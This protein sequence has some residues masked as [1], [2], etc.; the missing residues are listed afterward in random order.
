MAGGI[1]LRPIRKADAETL[2]KNINNPKIARYTLNIPHPYKLKD[3]H[4]W[5][6]HNLKIRKK[7]Q[8]EK[9]NW[10]IVKD[11]EV[12]GSV[13]INTLTYSGIY[14]HRAE[15][16]YWLAEQYWG[17]G[18]MPA[19]VKKVITFGFKELGLRRIEAHVF[20]A[21][22]QSARVLEKNGFKQEGFLKKYSFKNGKYIDEYLYAKVK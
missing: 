10:M 15:F 16:G 6:E 8:P 20:K 5:I 17:Q 14:R 13:G 9:I 1:L 3:A 19:A 2:T 4:W 22:K 21:N 12:I 18:I 7:K 11:G